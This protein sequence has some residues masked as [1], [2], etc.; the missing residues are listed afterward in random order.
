MASPILR[1]KERV[2]RS[3]DFGSEGSYAVGHQKAPKIDGEPQ[4]YEAGWLRNARSTSWGLARWGDIGNP[5]PPFGLISCKQTESVQLELGRFD[6]R[7]DLAHVARRGKYDRLSTRAA[8]ISATQ[9]LVKRQLWSWMYL[10][11]SSR[12]LNRECA[13]ENRCCRS[14]TR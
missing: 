4:A 13:P 14:P 12:R 6:P 3:R 7:L 8:A 11:K 10:P 5:L 1:E 9:I 2:S